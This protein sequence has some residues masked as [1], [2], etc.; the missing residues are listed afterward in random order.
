MLEVRSGL[1]QKGEDDAAEETGNKPADLAGEAVAAL[2]LLLGL[3][4]PGDDEDD[5]GETR[6]NASAIAE[7]ALGLELPGDDEDDEGETRGE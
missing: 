4:F 1:E 2:A 6:G 3:E 7:L 5:E